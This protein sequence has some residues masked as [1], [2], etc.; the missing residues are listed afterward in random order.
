MNELIPIKT[1]QLVEVGENY[2]W[3]WNYFLNWLDERNLSINESSL[4]RYE[5]YLK[6]SDYKVH[7]FNKK[8]CSMKA[9]I[10]K[11][12]DQSP[13]SF[14]LNMKF[15][16]EKILKEIKLIKIQSQEVDK[17]LLP[18]EDE[19]KKLINRAHENIGLFIEFL[20]HTG[21]RVSEMLDIKLN[22]IREKK[23]CY[24]IAVVGKGQKHRILNVRKDLIKRVIEYF[25]SEKWLFENLRYNK[26]SRRYVSWQ[27]HLIGEKVLRKR[28]SSHT[29]RHCFAT[30]T[31]KKTQKIKAVSKYLGHSSVSVTLDMYCHEFLEF[32]EL[33]LS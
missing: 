30:H 13:S 19:I 2:I 21:A 1:K 6:E 27:I 7:N 31:I 25:E 15:K 3:D 12:F 10:R 11:I 29:M 17:D 33:P 18:T 8:I 26:F 23:E 28:I 4:K 14:D 24:K 5:K 32:D 20:Y 9:G 16:L 22:D